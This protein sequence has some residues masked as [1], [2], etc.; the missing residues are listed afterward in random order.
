MLNEYLDLKLKGGKSVIETFFTG[1]ATL[2]VNELLLSILESAI[3]KGGAA[4]EALLEGETEL[5]MA[6][7]KFSFFRSGF[8][9]FLDHRQGKAE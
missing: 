4:D 1:S 5:R 6:L 8:E 9:A 2:C 7:Y 3:E